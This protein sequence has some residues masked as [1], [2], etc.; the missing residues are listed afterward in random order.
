MTGADAG[1]IAA[2]LS[3]KERAALCGLSRSSPSNLDDIG[4]L[5]ALWSLRSAGLVFVAA[6]HASPTPMGEEVKNRLLD[7]GI[8][9]A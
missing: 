5:G 9:S 6:N 7:G 4:C 1:V 3:D 2:S 8:A